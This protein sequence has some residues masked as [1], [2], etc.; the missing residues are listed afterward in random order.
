MLHIYRGGGGGIRGEAVRVVLVQRLRRCG[1]GTRSACGSLPL[2]D[3]PERSA[4]VVTVIAAR[5]LGLEVD[6]D[7]FLIEETRSTRICGTDVAICPNNVAKIVLVFLLRVHTIVLVAIQ[8]QAGDIVEGVH[9]FCIIAISVG[10]A[11]VK[12][13]IE[14]V[15]G[16]RGNVY[17]GIRHILRYFS[18]H[19]CGGHIRTKRLQCAP[20]QLLLHIDSIVA[21]MGRLQNTSLSSRLLAV[22]ETVPAIR[23]AAAQLL[24]AGH[25]IG[26]QLR[27]VAALRTGRRLPFTA[28]IAASAIAARIAA[29][30]IAFS[31]LQHILE[32]LLEDLQLAGVLD[33]HVASGHR[34]FRR[35]AVLRIAVEVEQLH[36]SVDAHVVVPICIASKVR[37]ESD[38]I[39]VGDLLVA[40]EERL[41]EEVCLHRGRRIEVGA[42]IAVRVGVVLD[43]GGDVQRD[44]VAVVVD[45]V[46]Q[47][48]E[49]THT[50]VIVKGFLDGVVG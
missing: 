36:C 1:H 34:A 15:D 23:S 35:R 3:R 33:L 42:G 50:R 46:L 14:G 2:I 25:V 27:D 17:H 13:H 7:V 43:V 16:L 11:L 9:L 6:R 38:L 44:G 5:V 18:L 41:L 28:R 4:R 45:H 32:G 39:D 48:V 12:D 21:Q 26:S 24:D 29:S 8:L 10:H 31:T 22:R 49:V 30:A 20:V 40:A 19:A 37:L 47:P